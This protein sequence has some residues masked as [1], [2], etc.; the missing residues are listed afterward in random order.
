MKQVPVPGV[1]LSMMTGA[2]WSLSY[3]LP[4]VL[5]NDHPLSMAK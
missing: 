5:S 1:S 2:W 3:F 4:Y